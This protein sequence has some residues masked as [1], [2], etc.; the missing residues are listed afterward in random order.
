MKHMHPHRGATGE[1]R[2]KEESRLD[3][4]PQ[5]APHNRNRLSFKGQA[6]IAHNNSTKGASRQARQEGFHMVGNEAIRQWLPILGPNA[7]AVL[8]ILNT[9][10]NSQDRLAWPGLDTLARHTGLNTTT[11]R[12]ALVILEATG[13][14]VR[15]PYK[16][17]LKHLADN[18]LPKKRG[19]PPAI[20]AV[21]SLDRLPSVDRQRLE[22]AIQK[23][24][25]A[26]NQHIG[27]YIA[28]FVQRAQA[29]LDDL[30]ATVA[31][32]T[33]SER[34]DQRPGELSA[35]V[36]Q[37]YADSQPQSRE[38]EKELGATV[39]PN[40]PAMVAHYS[41]L[42]ATVAGK[43]AP[44]GEKQPETGGDFPATVAGEQKENIV[45]LE[46]NRLLGSTNNNERSPTKSILDE[47]Q[48]QRQTGLARSDKEAL[49]KPS[50]P[51][52]VVHS[53]DNA[54]SDIS[55]LRLWLK[56][57]GVQEPARTEILQM[58]PNPENVIGWVLF[59]ATLETLTRN[60]VG[61]V[62][63]RLR[64]GAPPPENVLPLARALSR[65]TERDVQVLARLYRAYR[66]MY[67]PYRAYTG[68]YL[69]LQDLIDVLYEQLGEEA[70]SRW[71]KQ[72]GRGS[73]ELWLAYL[74]EVERARRKQETLRQV[75]LPWEHEWPG[76]EYSGQSS[77]NEA[78]NQ[79]NTPWKDVWSRAKS[80]LQA[81]M[82]RRDYNTWIRDTE[83]VA[84][85]ETDNGI[86]FVLGVGN[87]LAKEWLRSRLNEV[88]RKALADAA[89]LSVDCVNLSYIVNISSRT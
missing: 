40:L 10:A 34:E 68:A 52:V 57:A 5:A 88:V 77:N 29:V 37:K 15:I 19:R 12:A 78:I 80:I 54:E 31:Q 86:D 47:I 89:A 73:L 59:A 11:V 1:V 83:I 7:W 60:P 56:T 65:F 28:A 3:L 18:R 4:A 42:L 43:S 71:L 87:V 76:I 27:K 9:Y 85:E 48:Q 6:P 39:A 50:Q 69:K 30:P 82:S 63:N 25:A 75:Q 61:L 23:A 45:F 62:V 32:K 72:A 33:V 64:E 70:A 58:R 79:K 81:Q 13:C 22:E 44:A 55:L 49:P 8:S 26:S 41:D 35:T 66:N 84:V 24:Q 14:I 38:P 20:W 16:D 53:S 46:E 2:R 17:A 74:N 51:V 67:S 21:R 36:A